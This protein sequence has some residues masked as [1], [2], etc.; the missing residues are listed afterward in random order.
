MLGWAADFNKRRAKSHVIDP[1]YIPAK[2][3]GES[4]AF[5]H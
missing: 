2:T 3:P 1:F 4:G 5:L